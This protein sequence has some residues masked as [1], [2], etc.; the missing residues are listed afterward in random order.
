MGQPPPATRD[1]V[2]DGGE[3]RPQGAAKRAACPADRRLTPPPRGEGAATRSP[4]STSGGD[5]CDAR[6]DPALVPA[7]DC[8]KV[9]VRADA[10]GTSRAHEG[11]SISH[12]A[13][14]YV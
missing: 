8:T 14:G 1:R 6:R 4:G 3:P 11:A 10:S 9:D 5:H 7:V 13:V 12:C 2:P